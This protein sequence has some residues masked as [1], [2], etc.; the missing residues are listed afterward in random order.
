MKKKLLALLVI[1]LILGFLLVFFGFHQNQNLKFISPLATEQKGLGPLQKYSFSNL[2]KR[3]FLGSEIKLDRV[4]KKDP[5]F[6]SYLFFYQ[7]AGKRVSGLANIPAGDP[8]GDG[9]P[10]IVMIR[11][12]VDDKIYQTGVGTQRPAEYFAS[13]GFITLAPD[14][15]GFGESEDTYSDILEDRF[16]HPVTVL[17]LLASV[18]TLP[19]HPERSEGSQGDSSPANGGIRMTTI[20]AD[21][22]KIA[23]WA[24]SNGGQIA[25]SVLEISKKAYP[26]VLWAPV[27]KGFPDSVL[28]YMSQLDDLGVQVENRINNFVKDYNPGEFS[29]TNYF[30]DIKSALQVHQGTS[31]EYIET[32][33][34]DNFVKKLKSLGKSVEYYKYDGDNHNLSLNWETATARSLEFFRKFIFLVPGVGF[35]PTKACAGSFTDCSV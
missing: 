35:A 23:I 28:T 18:K 11:G 4:L 17:D 29:I 15:L 31:D 9:F 6:T 1:L 26:T 14:F 3:F 5:G 2:Q 13:H 7:S 34:T 10:V 20:C 22:K 27:T 8:P 16:V 21:P 25:I 24:H 33:W 30:S 12:Y 19:C 32:G